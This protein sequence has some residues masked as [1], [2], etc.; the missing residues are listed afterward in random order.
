M[1]VNIIEANSF[2]FYLALAFAGGYLRLEKDRS[3]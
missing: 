3:I 1:M 2:H